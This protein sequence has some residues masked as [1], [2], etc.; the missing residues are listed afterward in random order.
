MYR[1]Y[2][3]WERSG[4]LYSRCYCNQASCDKICSALCITVQDAV[5]FV[6]VY[7]VTGKGAVKLVA[8]YTINFQRTLKYEADCSVIGKDALRHVADFRVN[9]VVA[10]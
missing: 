6:A 10:V 1:I 9:E 3:K 2:Y 8:D 4:K 5:Y 7:S